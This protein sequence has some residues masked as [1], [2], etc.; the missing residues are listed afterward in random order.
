MYCVSNI[1]DQGHQNKFFQFKPFQ[2]STSLLT[3][4]KYD[5][6]GHYLQ[7]IYLSYIVYVAAAIHF[8]IKFETS[9]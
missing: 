1:K 6:F 9:F 8:T 7:T 3:A 2:L 5:S 4:A